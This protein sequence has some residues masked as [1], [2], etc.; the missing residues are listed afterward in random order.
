V[1]NLH[2]GHVSK[3][4]GLKELP[5]ESNNHTLNENI[6]TYASLT[7]KKKPKP[8]NEKKDDDEEEKEEEKPVDPVKSEKKSLFD[9]LPISRDFK[10]RA[11]FRNFSHISEF[12]NGLEVS[13]KSKTNKR[14]KIDEFLE[15]KRERNTSKRLFGR[16]K[17]NFD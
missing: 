7:I 16:N 15:K 2:R 12:G 10:P 4:F 11:R 17:K 6:I 13:T 14:D 9:R 3:S 8:S 1:K 5:D